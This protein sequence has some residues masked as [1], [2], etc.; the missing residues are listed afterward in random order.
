[1]SATRRYLI[2]SIV[3]AVIA[4]AIGAACAV[5]WL[6]H[7]DQ[8]SSLHQLVH[9]DLGLSSE[10]LTRIDPRRGPVRDPPRRAGAGDAGGQP[11]TGGRHRG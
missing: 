5:H 7:R 9:D 11:A 4:G 8:T 2:L 1:M 3:L 10:Q 6:S